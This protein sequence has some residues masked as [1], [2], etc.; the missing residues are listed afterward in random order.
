MKSQKEIEAKLEELLLKRKT[1]K[2][3]EPQNTY[4]IAKL[5]AEAHAL[6][7]VLEWGTK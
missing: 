7:W 1:A 2:E 6:R 3:K 4:F 5:K